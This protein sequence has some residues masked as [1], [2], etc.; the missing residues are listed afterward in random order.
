MVQNLG[1]DEHAFAGVERVVDDRVGC[2]NKLG[3]AACG[4]VE[5]VSLRDA[6]AGVVRDFEQS[7]CHAVERFGGE[8]LRDAE[9]AR[10]GILVEVGFADDVGHTRLDDLQ[11]VR[12]EIV[13]DVVVGP[14]M[15]VQQV[16]SHDEHLRARVRAVVANGSHDGHG[17]R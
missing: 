13:L 8:G 1:G 7:V 3:H 5:R 6:V 14:G 12:L 15:E 2:A 11:A 9:F 16:F 17:S 4:L 10:L